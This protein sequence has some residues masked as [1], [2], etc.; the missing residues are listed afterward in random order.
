M[1]LI[2]IEETYCYKHVTKYNQNMQKA[3]LFK[4]TAKLK[5]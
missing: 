2:Y 5:A 4:L 1:Y 3:G